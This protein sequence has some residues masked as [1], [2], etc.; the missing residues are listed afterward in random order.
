MLTRLCHFK[1]FNDN[2]EVAIK[3]YNFV[4]TNILFLINDLFF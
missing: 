4:S 2:T 1:G 3:V